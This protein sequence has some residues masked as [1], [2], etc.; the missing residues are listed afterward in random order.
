MLHKVYTW[1]PLEQRLVHRLSSI[2]FARVPSCISLSA[3]TRSAQVRGSSSSHLIR[4]ASA[5]RFGSPLC[6]NSR[7]LAT[8]PHS[9]L[10]RWMQRQWPLVP[11]L[12]ITFMQ[13][14]DRVGNLWSSSRVGLSNADGL[15]SIFDGK[16]VLGSN[17]LFC[18]C[19]VKLPCCCGEHGKSGSHVKWP[20]ILAQTAPW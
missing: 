15:G 14:P 20:K 16:C 6:F 12:S 8:V 11:I 18:C 3:A 5:T 4:T 10:R 19:M 7:V 1:F 9:S 17:V 2:S 13:C